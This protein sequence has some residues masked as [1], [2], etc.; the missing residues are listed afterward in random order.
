MRIDLFNSASSQI[1]NEQSSQ[2]I[3]ANKA[4]SST[5]A[6]GDEDHATLTSDK[7]SVSALVSTAMGSPEIRQSLVSSLRDSVNN[8]S[9]S[10]DPDKIAAS[11]VDDHA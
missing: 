2:Q 4:A 6:T 8:G 9:Y 11:M 7:S 3:A 1:A 10:L 5:S